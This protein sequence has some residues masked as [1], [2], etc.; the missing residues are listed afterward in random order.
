MTLPQA[1]LAGILNPATLAVRILHHDM[2]RT[3]NGIEMRWF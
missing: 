3:D 1:E 2:V